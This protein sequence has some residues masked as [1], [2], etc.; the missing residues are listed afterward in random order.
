MMKLNPEIAKETL[1]HILTGT[2]I[3]YPLNIFF[4]YVI[5]EQWEI[6]DPFWISN[7]VTVWFSIVAFI[8]IYTVRVLAE[9]RK[10]NKRNK[11]E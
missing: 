6:T 7:I 1:V 11:P 4:L 2:I 9:K 5:I 10:L 8:R 3:N